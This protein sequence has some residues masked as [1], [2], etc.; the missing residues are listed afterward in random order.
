MTWV[1]AVRGFRSRRR[2]EE[3]A[4]V[5]TSVHCGS[6][7]APIGVGEVYALVADAALTRCED[8]AVAITRA[9]WDAQ[10]WCPWPP[11]IDADETVTDD[12]I[13]F[14]ERLRAAI[15]RGRSSTRAA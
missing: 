1:V 10:G 3:S 11:R 13:D 2:R 12:S 4:V 5:R 7:G 9:A 15:E 8:C 14:G 6:C